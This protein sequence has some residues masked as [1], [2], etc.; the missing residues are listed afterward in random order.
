VTRAAL[1]ALITLLIGGAACGRDPRV[2]DIQGR[3][4]LT[5]SANTTLEIV[6]DGDRYTATLAGGSPESA[7]AGAPADC[8]VRAA[9]AMR[10]DTF[11]ATFVGV[12]T[13]TFSYSDAKARAE[14]RQLHIARR[15]TGVEVTRADTEGYCGLGATFLGLY[16]RPP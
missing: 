8:Q 11:E 16:R 12:E 5:G 6:R 7:G 2:A 1:W 4:T 14:S 9:G 3:Y 10:G 15:A 13:D